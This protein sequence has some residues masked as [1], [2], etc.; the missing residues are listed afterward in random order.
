MRKFKHKLT[1]DV[2]ELEFDTRYYLI[3]DK[4]HIPSRLIENSND[5]QEVKEEFPK[6]LKNV[7]SGCNVNGASFDPVATNCNN[8]PPIYIL[9]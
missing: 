9:V 7:I 4:A 5:W 8:P 2:A 1:G 3:K 6:I